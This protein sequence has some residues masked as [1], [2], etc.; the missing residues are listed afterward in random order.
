M[1]INQK[2]YLRRTVSKEPN[3]YLRRILLSKINHLKVRIN[4]AISRHND[5]LTTLDDL[6]RLVK[7]LNP[8]QSTIPPLKA[9]DLSHTTN[10]QEQCNVLANAFSNNMLLTH[11]WI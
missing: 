9:D 1:M 3:Y 5:K 8:K 10:P 7:N 11:D 2:N 6:W 4:D